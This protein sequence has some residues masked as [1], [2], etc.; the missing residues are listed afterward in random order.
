MSSK[1]LTNCLNKERVTTSRAM[2]H[3]TY[4]DIC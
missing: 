4:S 2:L 1:T 3:K